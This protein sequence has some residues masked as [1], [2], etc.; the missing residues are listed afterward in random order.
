[1]IMEYLCVCIDLYFYIKY[2]FE[3]LRVEKI[4]F[5]LFYLFLGK[6]MYK[7]FSFDII[8]CI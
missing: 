7:K 4:L 1:M 5:L 2:V 8:L 3:F 6:Y